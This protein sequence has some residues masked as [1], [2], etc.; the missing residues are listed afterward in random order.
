MEQFTEAEKQ[1][2]L[3]AGWFSSRYGLMAGLDAGSAADRRNLAAFG[4]AWMGQFLVDWADA[5]RSLGAQGYLVEEGG[6]YSLTERGEAARKRLEVDAPFW[7]YEYNN[8]FARAANS[9]AHAVFCARVYGQNLCQ[10]GLADLAQLDK[11]LAVLRLSASDR[12]LDLGC[13]SGLITEYLHDLTGAAFVG[14][15][16]SA[17]AIRQAR[18]RTRAQS[19]RLAFSVGNMNRLAFSPRTFSAVVAIDTLYY[20]N[21]LAATLKQVIEALKPGGQL[22]LFYTQWINDLADEAKLRPENTELA[23]SLKKYGLQFTALELTRQ[24][25]E[26]WQKKVDV[27]AELKPEFAAEGNL[28]LYNYRYS[29]AARYASWDVRKRS[30][31]LYHARL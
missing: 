5:Y 15:D 31:H 11:L 1:L 26:H 9:H 22:G 24:E 12:V 25:A 14:V 7:L 29:E 19:S 23:V 21:D 6:A 20:V 13:G 18:T 10:H 27:L 28:D 30:R 2:L 3:A 4:R 8:F 16:I 17:E